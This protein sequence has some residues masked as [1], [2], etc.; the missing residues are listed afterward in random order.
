MINNIINEKNGG[1]CQ[2]IYIPNFIEKQYS[3]KIINELNKINDWK[4]GKTKD[5]RLIQRKQKW[6]HINKKP[7]CKDWKIQYDRWKSHTYSEFL[8]DIQ[9]K[10][11]NQINNYLLNNDKIQK[12]LYN[13]LL[14]NYYKDGND[15]IAPHQDNKKSFGNN[16]TIALLSFGDKRT[17]ILERTKKNL[18]KRNK[19]EY[20]LNKKFILENNSLLI[21]AGDTQKYYC[22]YIPKENNKGKRYS[23]TFREFLN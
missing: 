15:Q 23:L 21:M 2:L 19:E 12:P 16:P 5:G 10:V 14:I 20:Y 3:N 1:V 13:S 7:F 17:F 18:L 11:Q 8:L 4:T 6:Y 9:N 22:H